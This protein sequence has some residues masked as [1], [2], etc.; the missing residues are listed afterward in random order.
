M[1]D[2]V[3]RLE[4]IYVW[5]QFL[6]MPQS[7]LPGRQAIQELMTADKYYFGG[8]RW[9]A[10]RDMR[11]ESTGIISPLNYGPSLRT[12]GWLFPVESSVGV[13][14]PDPD[15]DPVLDDF[16]DTIRTELTHDAFN[17][18]GPATVS[19]EDAARWGKLW[20]LDWVAEGEREVA[21]ARLGGARASSVRRK[22]IALITAAHKDL[23][24]AAPSADA[25]RTRMAD[26]PASWREAALRPEIST[27]WQSSR[28]DS[29]FASLSK[30]CFTGRSARW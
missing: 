21:F 12:L 9:V 26:L 16:E 7:D 15:I 14:Q 11:R 28:S 3:D 27:Q 10:R 13:F 4:A 8:T 29:C 6:Y 23:A 5:S 18:F 20:A 17:K 30:V 19:R 22:G 1:R 2:F 24:E 25:L